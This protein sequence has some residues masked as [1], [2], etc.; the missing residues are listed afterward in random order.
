MQSRLL[1]ATAGRW[2]VP[3]IEESRRL[4]LKALPIDSDP[5]AAGFQY[6]Q[7]QI[8]INN[9]NNYNSIIQS[10]ESLK[11]TPVGAVSYCSEAGQLLAS[12]LRTHFNLPGDNLQ[13]TNTFTHKSLQRDIWQR[14]FSDNFQWKLFEN[15]TSANNY[16]LERGT[17]QVVKPDAG[18][19]SKGVTILDKIDIKSAQKA[20]LLAFKE[21]RNNKIIIEDFF[22]GIEYTID[23]FS[24]ESHVNILLITKK[25]H[26]SDELRTVSLQLESLKTNS[27]EYLIIANVAA[28]AIQSLGKIN[29]PAHLEILMNQKG[30][31]HIIEASSRGGGFNLA[32]VFIRKVT[33]INYPR[34]CVKDAVG[35]PISKSEV[36]PQFENH[37]ILRFLVSSAGKVTKIEGI[38]QVNNV[39]GMYAESFTQIGRVVKS[40]RSDGDRLGC[41]ISIDRDYEKM[42]QNL[43]WSLKAVSFKID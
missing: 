18:S 33:G 2:Q 38:D 10:I 3:A 24:I 7:E 29:G 14:T 6:S 40:A 13:L 20:I 27:S 1:F 30:E 32:S 15:K 26:V 17:P 23:S 9:I 21:S 34:L 37:G 5:N 41:L 8:L 28:T 4:Q 35:I 25:T 11:I 19:G 22:Q 42:I 36:N 43:N 12:Q 31:I 39:R 16:I